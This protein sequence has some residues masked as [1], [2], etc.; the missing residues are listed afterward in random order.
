[1]RIKL[2]IIFQMENV[3]CANTGVG[4][5]NCCD[6]TNTLSGAKQLM[7]AR[8]RVISGDIKRGW[9]ILHQQETRDGKG[10]VGEEAIESLEEEILPATTS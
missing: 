5:V 1:M 7:V 3:F 10:I 2:P 6:L 9:A 4:I 8:K